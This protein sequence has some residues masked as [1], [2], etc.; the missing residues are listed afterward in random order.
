MPFI[1]LSLWLVTFLT[2]T[3][4]FSLFFPTPPLTLFFS[5]SLFHVFTHIHL[6]LL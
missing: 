6:F 5:F 1:S 2:S 4:T 3:L